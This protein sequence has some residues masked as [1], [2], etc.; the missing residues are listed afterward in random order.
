MFCLFLK[1]GQT[2]PLNRDLIAQSLQ[3][4]TAKPLH[5]ERCAKQN[6]SRLVMLNKISKSN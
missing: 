1:Y 5:Q 4:S 3:N 6:I 2:K